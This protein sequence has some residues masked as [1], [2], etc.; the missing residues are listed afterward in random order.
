MASLAVSH[1]W[2]T[3]RVYGF[4]KYA[5][6]ARVTP[7]RRRSIHLPFSV[8]PTTLTVLFVAVISGLA[9]LSLLHSNVT[10]TKGYQFRAVQREHEELAD[11]TK[12]LRMRVAELQALQNIDVA[13]SGMVVAR[14]VTRVTVEQHVALQ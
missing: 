1:R 12:T 4:E 14:D 10:A 2:S 9:V 5:I 3:T 13:S 8:G 11:Q 6:S 7:T